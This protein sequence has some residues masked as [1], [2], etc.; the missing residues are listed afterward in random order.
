MLGGRWFTPWLTYQGT[1]ESS[2]HGGADA[3]LLAQF[4]YG[5]LSLADSVWTAVRVCLDAILSTDEGL[6]DLCTFAFVALQLFSAAER[7]W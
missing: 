5:I 2:A 6:C 3:S 4:F 1:V 7:H